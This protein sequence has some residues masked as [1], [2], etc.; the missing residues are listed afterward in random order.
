MSP[1]GSESLSW[2]RWNLARPRSLDFQ[3]EVSWEFMLQ[4]PPGFLSS[5]LGLSPSHGAFFL[6]VSFLLSFLAFLTSFCP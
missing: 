6:L 1:E 2:P 3:P 5:E 4:R